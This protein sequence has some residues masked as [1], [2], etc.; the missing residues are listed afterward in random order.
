MN[1]KNYMNKMK[2][3][4]SNYPLLLSPEICPLAYVHVHFCA[5]PCK[6]IED[7]KTQVATRENVAPEAV[8]EEMIAKHTVKGMVLQSV[9]FGK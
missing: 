9:E 3:T 1:F 5:E 6:A 7:V 8:T 4:P 2:R